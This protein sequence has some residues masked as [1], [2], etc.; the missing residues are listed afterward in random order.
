MISAIGH[1]H[2]GMA[3]LPLSTTSTG[4]VLRRTEEAPSKGVTPYVMH[5]ACRKDQSGLLQGWCGLKAHFAAPGE[6]HPEKEGESGKS[7][8]ARQSGERP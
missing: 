1:S 4:P 2:F 6:R 8:S 3:S 5:V 7:K